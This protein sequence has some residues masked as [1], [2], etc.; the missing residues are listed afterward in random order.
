MSSQIPEDKVIECYDR[1]NEPIFTVEI[2]D[3]YLC[4][5]DQPLTNGEALRQRLSSDY[6]DNN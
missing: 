1:T 3:R 5:D 6:W 4:D 2:S